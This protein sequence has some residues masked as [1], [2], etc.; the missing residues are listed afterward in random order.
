MVQVVD[1]TKTVLYEE[2]YAQNQFLAITNATVSHELR[3]PLQSITSQNL[4]I[5]LC[6]KELL[7]LISKNDDK[8]MKEMK[9]PIKA[10]VTMIQGSN[11]IQESSANM[12]SFLVDDLLDFAQLNAGQF[13]KIIKQFDVKDAIQECVR[14]QAEKAKMQGIK[15]TSKYVPQVIGCQPSK[16]VSLFSDHYTEKIGNESEEQSDQDK[17]EEEEDTMKHDLTAYKWPSD[18]LNEK[19]NFRIETDKRRLQQII[20][21][22]QSNA[23]KFTEKGGSVTLYYTMY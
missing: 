5:S 14:I 22:L 6:L 19:P 1:V 17:E 11:S 15:L 4:K 12:M 20:I 3:N 18:R 23:L 2:I 9:K 7:Q 16:I 8:T 13:R 21:N 10:L